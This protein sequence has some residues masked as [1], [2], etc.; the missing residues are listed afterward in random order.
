[1]RLN[2][3]I[4]KMKHTFPILTLLF[5]LAISFNSCETRVDLFADYKDIPIIYGL[6][7]ATQDTNYVKI[8]RAFSNNN[9][10][11]ISAHDIALIADSSNYPG[12]LDARL[13]ELEKTYGNHYEPTGREII[14][15][16]MTLHHKDSGEFYYPHQK[17]YYTAETLKTNTGSHDYKYRLQILKGNDT[18]TSTTGMVGGNN[19]KITN[20]SIAFDPNSIEANK[21][22]FTEAQNAYAFSAKLRFEYTEALP[23]QTSL[24]Q[25]SIE[26]S[27]G[28]QALNE[29]EYSD[30]AYKIKY[31]ENSLFKY[32][33]GAIGGDTLNAIRYIGDFYITLAAG[34]SELY[35][36]IEVNSPSGSISQN[37]PDYTN[38]N[39]GYGIFSSRVNIEKKVNL[40]AATQRYLLGI[41]SW[42]F[43]PH[44]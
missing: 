23:G 43:H 38:I 20:S 4:N 44:P 41:E 37:I 24:T 22:S 10:N 15:D 39:G 28:Y 40:S 27:L 25:K 5:A 31:M 11:P 12:K 21:I 29:L 6:L 32:L 18:I 7:D 2:K 3:Q 14:L 36:Y 8:V 42:G 26:W 13:I 16:T 1:M 30:G 19:F 9:E 33:S 35:N 17:I 34:G